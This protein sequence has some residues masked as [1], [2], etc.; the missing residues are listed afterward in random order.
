MIEKSVAICMLARDC[1]SA[2]EKNIQ[3]IEKLRRYFFKSYV[4]IIENDSKDGTKDVLHNWSKTSKNIFVISEDTGKITIPPADV[5]GHLRGMSEYRISK[6]A[7]FR[8]K[9][10]DFVSIH[11]ATI[12]YL[13][14]IDIDVYDFDVESVISAIENAPDDWAAI[15]ADGRLFAK[16]GKVIIPSKYYDNYT[17]VP[18]EYDCYDTTFEEM[19]INSSK[20]EKKLKKQKYVPCKAAF[21]GLSVY[22][23]KFLKGFHYEALKNNRSELMEVMCCHVSLCKHMAAY[24]KNYIVSDMNLLY[25]QIKTIGEFIVFFIGNKN[26]IKLWELIKRKKLI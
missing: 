1:K 14:N 5:D 24:G 12:D 21:G 16:I 25:D 15:F 17:Y 18:Y 8:N 4:V 11:D 19:Y 20:L 3:K 10:L 2:L 26:F 7:G 22:K 9:Y 13:I 23:Y 6:M